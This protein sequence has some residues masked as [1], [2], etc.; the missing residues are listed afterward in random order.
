MTISSNGENVLSDL[1]VFKQSGDYFKFLRFTGELINLELLSF[2]QASTHIASADAKK[3]KWQIFGPSNHRAKNQNFR[4]PTYYIPLN[5]EFYVD[6]YSQKKG[7]TLKSN[8]KKD[9]HSVSLYPKTLFRAKLKMFN[10]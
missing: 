10:N 5:P 2:T 8:C 6:H 9:I 3:S 7:Y 1:F 4:N